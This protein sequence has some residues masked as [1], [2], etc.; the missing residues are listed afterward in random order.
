MR[1]NAIAL[2]NRSNFNVVSS[3]F[4]VERLR[5][6]AAL[7]A[8][9]IAS[10][11]SLIKIR[12]LINDPTIQLSYSTEIFDCLMFESRGRHIAFERIL[13]TPL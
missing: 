10:S 13:N 4:R 8:C 2:E 5:Y 3:P 6:P 12:S 9:T 7:D 1:S 11:N